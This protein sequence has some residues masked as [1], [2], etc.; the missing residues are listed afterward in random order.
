MTSVKMGQLLLEWVAILGCIKETEHD[1]LEGWAM[2]WI[3][4]SIT[5][6]AFHGYKNREKRE[7]KG[8]MI[9]M[10]WHTGKCMQ[11]LRNDF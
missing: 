1:L 5:T 8:K 2:N 6:L 10:L 7:K 3:S 11:P 9:I 4:A